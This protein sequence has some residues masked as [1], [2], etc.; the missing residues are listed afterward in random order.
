MVAM[1]DYA[2]EGAASDY[3]AVDWPAKDQNM[4]L[5]ASAIS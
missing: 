5:S 1:R 3:V 4:S 2:R